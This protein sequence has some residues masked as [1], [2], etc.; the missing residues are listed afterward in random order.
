MWLKCRAGNIVN[1]PTTLLFFL[2]AV[3]VMN[4]LKT[5]KQYCLYENSTTASITMT[6]YVWIH[7]L[8]SQI[9][10]L[11]SANKQE[12]QERNDAFP[13][14]SEKDYSNVLL[15]LKAVLDLRKYPF[16]CP[17]FKGNQKTIQNLKIFM[18]M[19]CYHK[20]SIPF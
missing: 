13:K 6:L 19:V 3:W 4:E 5:S 11:S 12:K 16:S 20:G 9:I 7:T 10:S 1:L 18:L 8:V 2:L 14:R 17:S 15:E